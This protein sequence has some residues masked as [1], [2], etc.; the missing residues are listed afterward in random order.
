M[1]EE[2][3]AIEKNKTWDLV[4]LPEEKN[5]IG[6]KRVYCTKYRADRTI[7][8]HKARLVAKGYAQQQGVNFDETFSPVARFLYHACFVPIGH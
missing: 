8:K 6:L 2:L 7:Q 5:V 3:L 1:E 4:D